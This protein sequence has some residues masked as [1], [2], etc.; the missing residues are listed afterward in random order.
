MLSLVQELEAFAAS[1][2]LIDLL[3]LSGDAATLTAVSFGWTRLKELL[4]APREVPISV[5]IV[6]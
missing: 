5:S 2:A 1:D 3:Q 6:Y 4:E